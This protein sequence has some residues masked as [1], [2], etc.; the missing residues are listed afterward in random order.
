MLLETERLIIRDLKPEDEAPFVELASDGSLKDVGFD[1]DCNRW[2]RNW[3][4]EAEKLAKADNP[5][6]DY[7]AYTIVLKE[8]ELVIGSIGCSYYDD[9]QE[10]G[11]TYFI[12]AQYRN[13]GYATEAAKVYIE[14]FINRYDIPRLI[15]TVREENISSWRIVE[16]AGFE[17]VEKKLYKDINDDKEEMYRF[18]E[19]KNLTLKIQ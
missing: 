2:M 1:R 8:K 6:A 7:L 17:F 14:Y 13:K 18:Y 15:A 9:F 4:K 11:I 5:A 19:I 3:I 12:G 10:T 16:K